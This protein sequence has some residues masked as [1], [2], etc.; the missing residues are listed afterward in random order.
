ME[1]LSL[2]LG[3][4]ARTN[5]NFSFHPKCQPLN[6]THL[7][8]ADD[9]LIFSTIALD[10]VRVLTEILVEFESLSG[11]RAN[12]AKSTIF[13]AGASEQEKDIL[14]LFQMNEGSLLVRYLGV[15]LITKKLSAT[16]CECLVTKVSAKIDSWLVK[17][18]S[19]AG[20]L[21]LISSVL[22]SL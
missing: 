4:A 18:L 13:C 7:C 11:L 21:Q 1:I 9:L 12:P 17:N 2:L 5:S 15:P 16:D 22:C 19:F 8:F 14:S 3:E 10:Y 20:R 6:L